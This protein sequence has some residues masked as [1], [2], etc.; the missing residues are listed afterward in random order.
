LIDE[1]AGS[2]TVKDVQ[3]ECSSLKA[4]E[5]QVGETFSRIVYYTAYHVSPSH[6]SFKDEYGRESVVS[7]EIV[8]DT[9]QSACQYHGAPIK[10]SQTELIEKFKM[11]TLES[12]FTVYFEKQLPKVEESARLMKLLGDPEKI[13]ELKT[14]RSSC[15]KYIRDVIGKKELR[16]LVGRMVH[17]GTSS[18]TSTSHGRFQVIDMLLERSE[19]SDIGGTIQE[20]EMQ[21]IREKCT[22]QVDPRTI[23]KLIL[24]HQTY[25]LRGW[26]DTSQ[27]C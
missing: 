15:G 5:V 11:E 26:K 7:S 1:D 9:F 13:D 8:E 25:I 10:L 27:S 24:R 19:V 17:A 16:K 18:F 2:R 23:K 21:A 14:S 20:D 12:V 3:V 4:S 6:V 22:R